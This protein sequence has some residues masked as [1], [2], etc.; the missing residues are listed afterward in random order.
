MTGSCIRNRA[1]EKKS[2]SN[3]QQQK[4]GPGWLHSREFITQ[5]SLVIESN[6]NV[7]VHV[8]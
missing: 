2:C 3:G 5:F 1:N 6:Y 4:T 7:R 8:R